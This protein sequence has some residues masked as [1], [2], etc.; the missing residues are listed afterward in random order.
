MSFGYGSS[1]SKLKENK[2][3]YIGYTNKDLKHV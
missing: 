2:G 3:E 1:G